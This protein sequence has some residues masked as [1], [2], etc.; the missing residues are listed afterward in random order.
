MDD[1]IVR[2]LKRDMKA[3]IVIGMLAGPPCETWSIVRWQPD[4]FATSDGEAALGCRGRNI[5]A[6]VATY[7]GN[8]VVTHD[9]RACTSVDEGR[10]VLRD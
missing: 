10:G 7:G 4:V 6:E 3:G 8:Y 1:E 5:E 2:G 9:S